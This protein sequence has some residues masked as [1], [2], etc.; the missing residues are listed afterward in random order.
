M[1][2]N[3]EK[4]H[5]FLLHEN[6]A[7]HRSV[8]VKNFLAKNNVTTMEHPSYSPGLASADLFSVPS[9]EINIQGRALL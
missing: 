1:E 6:A 3:G 9:T 8:L 7:L 2:T 5:W 4:N